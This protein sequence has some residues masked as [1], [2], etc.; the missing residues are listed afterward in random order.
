MGKA[1]PFRISVPDSVLADLRERLG[2]ARFAPDFAN[3][4]WAYGTE[5]SYLEELIAYWRDEYDWRKHEA[6]MNAFCKP[7]A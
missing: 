5:R 1:E 2:R 3:S 6:A 7:S 4:E